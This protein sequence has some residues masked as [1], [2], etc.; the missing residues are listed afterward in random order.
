MH[1]LQL[2]FHLC[3]VDSSHSVARYA[4]GAS[5]LDLWALTFTTLCLLEIMSTTA[6]AGG[7]IRVLQATQCEVRGAGITVRITERCFVYIVLHCAC[8]GPLALLVTKNGN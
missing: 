8:H 7:N 3:E 6:A 1:Q 4:G 2:V 5:H